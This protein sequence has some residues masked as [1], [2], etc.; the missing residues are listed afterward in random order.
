MPRKNR[1]KIFA[2]YQALKGF[3]ETVRAKDAAYMR[4]PEPAEY[5]RKP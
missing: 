2:P 1:A 5:A 4:R 3:S